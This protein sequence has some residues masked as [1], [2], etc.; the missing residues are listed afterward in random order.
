VITRPEFTRRVEVRTPSGDGVKT[1]SFSATFRWVPGDDLEGFDSNT[2]EG[3][4]DLLR[5]V[6]VRADELVGTNDEPLA[7]SPEIREELLSWSNVRVALLL[8]YNKAWVEEK[9]GN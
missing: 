7:W 6:L 2:S 9:R 3:V 4:K 5:S 1:E 8:A